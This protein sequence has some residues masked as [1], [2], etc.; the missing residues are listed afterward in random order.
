MVHVRASGAGLDLAGAVS[1]LSGEK[2]RNELG[3]S[4]L[5]FCRSIRLAFD[6]VAEWC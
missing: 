3:L 2:A 5:Y 1:P 6:E 4:R